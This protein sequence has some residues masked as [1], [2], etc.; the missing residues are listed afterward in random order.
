MNVEAETLRDAIT[1]AIVYPAGSN[2]R[3]CLKPSSATRSGRC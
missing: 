1:D 2:M 3:D